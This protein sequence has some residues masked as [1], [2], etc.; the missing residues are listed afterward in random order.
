[1]FSATAQGVTCGFQTARGL[2]RGKK[3][4]NPFLKKKKKKKRF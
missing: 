4:K 3:E 1:L 2:K